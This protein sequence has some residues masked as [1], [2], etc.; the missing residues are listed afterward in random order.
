MFDF[1]KNKGKLPSN[2]VPFPEHKSTP[3]VPKVEPPP[4]KEKPPTV[5]YRFGITDQNR[6]A[7]QMGYSE[8]TM[9][10]AGVQSLIDQLEFYKERMDDGEVE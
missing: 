9:N 1:F 8:I 6:L 7:F 2:V 5:F 10:R 3:A 4:E